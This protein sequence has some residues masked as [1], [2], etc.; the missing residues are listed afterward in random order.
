MLSHHT[1]Q[2]QQSRKRQ[3]LRQ[4]SYTSIKYILSYHMHVPK[5]SSFLKVLQGV[6]YTLHKQN[7]YKEHQI[8]TDIKN[9][10]IKQ[11]L[12]NTLRLNFCYLKIIRFL[13]SRYHPK[14]NRTYSYCLYKNKQCTIT[15]SF[16]NERDSL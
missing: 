4:A 13:H 2:L 16:K 12:S 5:S 11:K 1:E 9:Q 3:F 6:I 15:C 7:F 8:E 14:I 10:K